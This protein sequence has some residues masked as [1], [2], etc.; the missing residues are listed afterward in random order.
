MDLHRVPLDEWPDEAFLALHAMACQA[1]IPYSAP[2]N[3]EAFAAVNREYRRRMA[4]RYDPP[5]GG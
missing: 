2:G 4:M 3:R 5:A 1:Q